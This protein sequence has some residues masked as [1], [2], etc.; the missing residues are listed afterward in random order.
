MNFILAAA[1]VFELQLPMICGDTENILTGLRN[2]FKEEIVFMAP[3]QNAQGDVLSH[4]LWIN[5]DSSTWTFVVVNREK[6]TTCVIASGD[7]LQ[8][9]FPGKSI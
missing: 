6:E 4:S 8:M 9:Y 2:E 3:G 7:K 5:A 1:A